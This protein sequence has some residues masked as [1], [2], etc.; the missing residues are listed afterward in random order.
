MR[1]IILCY[2][3]VISINKNRSLSEIGILL[4]LFWPSSCK[5]R[6][7]PRRLHSSDTLISYPCDFS[8]FGLGN[9]I[10]IYDTDLK[11]VTPESWNLGYT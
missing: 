5:A 2:I 10:G 11:M 3:R 4:F 8:I 7:P 9:I 6:V 1:G